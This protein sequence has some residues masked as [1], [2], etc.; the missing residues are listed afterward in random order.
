MEHEACRG[1]RVEVINVDGDGR[2]FFS[3]G[4]VMVV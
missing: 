3:R 1:N 2:R 4:L